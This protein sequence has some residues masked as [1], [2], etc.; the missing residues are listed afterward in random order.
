MPPKRARQ[1][2][3]CAPIRMGALIFSCP[4]KMCADWKMRVFFFFF[5]DWGR[6]YFFGPPKNARKMESTC[7]L[8]GSAHFF[9]PRKDVRRLEGVRLF[10]GPPNDAR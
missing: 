7:V 2:E 3:R 8:E 1:L 5:A 9:L 4:G 10:F 6:A